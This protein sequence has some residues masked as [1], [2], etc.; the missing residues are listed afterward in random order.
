MKDKVAAL[1]RQGKSYRE[2]D[3]LLELP[4]GKAWQINNRERHNAN[5]RESVRRYVA[6]GGVALCDMEPSKK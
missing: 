2:I 5:S 6:R 1:R 4:L 3:F